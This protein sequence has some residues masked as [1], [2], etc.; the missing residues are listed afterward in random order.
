M[1]VFFWSAK[2]ETEKAEIANA[3]NEIDITDDEHMERES[4]TPNPPAMSHNEMITESSGDQVQQVRTV[5]PT[6][7]EITYTYH[8]ESIGNSYNFH[9]PFVYVRTEVHYNKLHI[10]S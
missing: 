2:I 3:D 7:P 9:L 6:L 8:E 4:I 5:L 10:V 1:K